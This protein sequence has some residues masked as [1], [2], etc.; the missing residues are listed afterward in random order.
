MKHRNASSGVL[1]IGSPLTLKDV[2]TITGQPVSS[3][4]FEINK[5]YIVIINN[6][7]NYKLLYE[8]FNSFE[9]ISYY[10]TQISGL[11]T[12]G[13]YIILTNYMSNSRKKKD[14]FKNWYGNFL[15]NYISK[16]KKKSK[17][18]QDI[19]LNKITSEFMLDYIYE[20][21]KRWCY[22]NNI[23][24]VINN[25][26]ISIENYK[27]LF[28]NVTHI[29]K[30][31][32]KITKE[33][34]FSISKPVHAE[35]IS[36]LITSILPNCHELTITDATANAGGNTINFSSY[37]K[38]VFSIEYEKDSYDCLVNNIKVY[39]LRNVETIYD[40]YFNLIN[41]LKQDV[42]FI[43]PPWGGTS[44]KVFDKIDLFLSGKYIGDIIKSLIGKAKL[45]CIKA[46]LN[47]DLNK[48]CKT[49]DKFRIYKMEKFLLVIYFN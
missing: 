39:N 6:I 40:D 37:F 32:L 11:E 47:F 3:L 21:S 27:Y 29:N 36:K 12:W 19:K 28:P 24:F 14:E 30:S 41:K 2:L 1:T 46:P 4:N 25:N 18:I 9:T 15:K 35:Q 48:L 7:L 33:S 49:I 31:K 22:D 17:L 8:Y 5:D 38:K 34:I 43:D 42:I 23:N 16:L 20:Q 26:I 44:Y 45:I 10:K 13:T